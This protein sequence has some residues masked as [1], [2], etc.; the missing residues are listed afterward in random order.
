[1]KEDEIENVCLDFNLHLALLK[2]VDLP[3]THHQVTFLKV[4]FMFIFHKKKSV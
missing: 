3:H 2:H 1:M 4:L